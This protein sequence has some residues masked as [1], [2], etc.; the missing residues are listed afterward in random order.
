MKSKYE[1][2]SYS[3]KVRPAFEDL[4]ISAL[5][6]QNA[7]TRDSNAV[8][9]K[10]GIDRE[11]VNLSQL[12]GNM[13]SE[14]EKLHLDM[15]EEEFKKTVSKKRKKEHE[16][17]VQRRNQS[18]NSDGL[19][20][21]GQISVGSFSPADSPDSQEG[22]NES[23]AVKSTPS[24]KTKTVN[25]TAQFIDNLTKAVVDSVNA[26]EPKS[27]DDRE[28]DTEWKKSQ[29]S[30]AKAQEKLATSQELRLLEERDLERQLKQAQI[31]AAKAQMNYFN[32]MS[33]TKL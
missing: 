24:S 22:I 18:I 33:A 19:K 3:I 32:N 9:T 14:Y 25:T 21:Q 26:S 31:D 8:L 10:Y 28:L 15:A 29:I 7:F 4:Q 17:Q 30:A 23:P 20:K 13:P 6:L 5:A 1:I 27:S 11:G 2:N 16:K 12:D